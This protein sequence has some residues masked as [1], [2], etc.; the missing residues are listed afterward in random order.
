MYQAINDKIINK[1]ENIFNKIIVKDK[2]LLIPYSQDE[3][4]HPP[5]L[6]EAV[7]IPENEKQ[8]IELVNLC[9]EEKIPL[10]TRG[11][12]TGVTGACIPIYGGIVVS[13][14]N[15]N[16]VTDIDND[17]FCVHAQPGVILENLHKTVEAENLFYPPDPNSLDSCT[18]GGNLST[19]AG[20]PRCVKY[21]I[22]RDYVLKTKFI[23]PEGKMVEFGG[24]Y[25]KISTGYN[26]THLMI[27][28][29]GT[30]GIITDILLKVIPKPD[31]VTDALAV[32][33]THSS[34]RSS[35]FK[36]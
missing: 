12:G 15:F 29:E 32:A 13:M 23:T 9:N 33:I 18:I 3:G 7:V 2:D 16:Q 27:G 20:G 17:N 28:A 19:S 22:T 10:T 6:P 36:K 5:S 1:L 21:G 31:D 4:Y 8:I 11:G 34:S 30:L 26:L 24:K 35:Q 14:K 25:N